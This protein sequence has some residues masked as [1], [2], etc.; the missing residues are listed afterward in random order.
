MVIRSEQKRLYK[1][2]SPRG[3]I[4]ISCDRKCPAAQAQTYRRTK[5]SLTPVPHNDFLHLQ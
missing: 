2:F 1:C 3:S 5:A 4:M